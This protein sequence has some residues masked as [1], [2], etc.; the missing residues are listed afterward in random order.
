MQDQ[1]FRP[2]T[3]PT[4]SRSQ[5]FGDVSQG[6]TNVE[7]ASAELEE[8]MTEKVEDLAREPESAGPVAEI[9][10][11]ETLAAESVASGPLAEPFAESADTETV[12]DENVFTEANSSEFASDETVEFPRAHATDDTQV[13][14]V[15]QTVPLTFDTQVLP[16]QGGAVSQGPPPPKI[17][18][19]SCRER[20]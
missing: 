4:P 12:S 18:R 20:V 17:G 13:L 6:L 8:V 15:N 2:P 16:V 9:A 14:E 5:E 10:D 3:S 11:A 19:A 1:D 7:A